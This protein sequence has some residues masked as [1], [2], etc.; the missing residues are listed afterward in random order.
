MNELRIADEDRISFTKFVRD[1]ISYAVASRFKADYP[2]DNEL[3]RESF[4]RLDSI[5]LMS[6]GE[7][8]SDISGNII[9]ATIQKSKE[10]DKE[11]LRGKEAGYN[12]IREEIEE[13]EEN[14]LRRNDQKRNENERVLRNGEYGRDNR[15]NQGEYA[16]QLGGTDVLYNGIPESDLRSDE[17][18]LSIT[19]RGAEPIRDVGGF[20]QGEE[21]D[22]SPDGY[23]E[24]SDRLYENREA[25]AD[26]SLED[27][28][29]ERS[30]VWSDDFGT[31]RDDHQ[32]NRGKIKENTEVEIRE[33][34]KASFSLPE[35]SYGQ[36]RLTIPLNQT[37]IDTILINGGNHDDGRLPVIAEFSKGKT[38]EELGE[39]LKD[40][41]RGGNG[42][43]IDE[44]EVSSWYSDKGIHLSYGT[45]SREDDTQILSW[46]DAA[47][48]IN[49][50]L[51][52]GE[53]ATNVELSEALDYERDRI[54][55]SVWYL[56]HDLSEEGKAHGYFDFIERGGGFP[57]ETKRLSDAL[58][59][60][61]YLRETIK[62][63]SRF[64]AG[65][66]ENRDVLR[67]H[68]HKV[69]SLY[70]RLQELEL[71]RKEYSTNMT[72]LPKVKSFITE[73]EVLESLS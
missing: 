3:L 42:F 53:F 11:V 67:F 61:E 21:A 39:Y 24:A 58:K 9:D 8:V 22:K 30:A 2:I 7:A 32:G 5:S 64:L 51:E 31:E 4:Q 69:D 33:A 45:S 34:D 47:S 72:E 29:R 48:R 1:S 50:L 6:L 59:N 41:F 57:E 37:E 46:N 54:S 18:G 65:Y 55:E 66:K 23:S 14:V 17:A 20:I 35:N 60:P 68:Y 62:E 73:D 28:G 44:R 25:E 40:T 71:P 12:R 52:T 70:K 19:E 27:R 56:Y 49:E 15:E 63:Y 43:Y 13:V 36:M 16:K 26:G 38:N 10:L